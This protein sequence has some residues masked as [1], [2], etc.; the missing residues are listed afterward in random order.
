MTGSI[1]LDLKQEICRL[2]NKLLPEDQKEAQ[3]QECSPRHKGKPTQNTV[4]LK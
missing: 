2:N 1:K 3:L 4:I